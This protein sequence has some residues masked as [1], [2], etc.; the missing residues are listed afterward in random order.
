MSQVNKPTA[1]NT[2]KRLQRA[3]FF[4][5]KTA[6]S[7][8]RKYLESQRELTSVKD[9]LKATEAKLARKGR[10]VSEDDVFDH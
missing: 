4:A 1:E 5:N 10:N 7:W 8:E 6:R 3:L 9:K 2:I